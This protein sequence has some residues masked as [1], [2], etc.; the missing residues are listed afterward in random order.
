MLAFARANV[1]RPFSNIAMAR[2]L[3]MPRRTDGKSYFCA[4][5]T[6]ACLQA[7]GLLSSSSNPG[8]AT[9]ASLYR[10]YSRRAATTV[11][12]VHSNPAKLDAPFKRDL[13]ALKIH[14]PWLESRY[15]AI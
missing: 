15:G 10:L 11:R 7:G 6:A 3:F 4:E 14:A 2:S 9:P 1:G 8:A 12:T 5:L 13:N